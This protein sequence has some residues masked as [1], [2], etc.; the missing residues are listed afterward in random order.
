MARVTASTNMQSGVVTVEI[1]ITA[2][3]LL[4]T[5]SLTVQ[6]SLDPFKQLQ[7]AACRWGVS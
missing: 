6:K 5:D 1:K 2:G 7:S 3:Q 4:R